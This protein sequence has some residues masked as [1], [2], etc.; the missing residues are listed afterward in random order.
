LAFGS[1]ITGLAQQAIGTYGYVV[2]IDTT[3]LLASV[4]D[5]IQLQASASDTPEPIVTPVTLDVLLSYPDD[6]NCPTA[7]FASSDGEC[8]IFLDVSDYPYVTTTRLALIGRR[9]PQNVSSDYEYLDMPDKDLNLAI[10]YCLKLAYVLKKAG[11]PKW[12]K[13]HIDAG[14]LSIRNEG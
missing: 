10:A 7:A 4:I 11:C 8:W 14:E 5:S 3:T 2:K 9:K 1:S 13:D 6:A 12:I